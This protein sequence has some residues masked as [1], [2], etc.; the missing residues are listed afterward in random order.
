MGRSEGDPG[1]SK[2]E[3]G[4]GEMSQQMLAA[5]PEDLGSIPSIHIVDHNHL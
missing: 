1:P 4:T 2:G 5:L 3:E